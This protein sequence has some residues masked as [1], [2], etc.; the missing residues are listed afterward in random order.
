MNNKIINGFCLN[1]QELSKI[2]N[3]DQIKDKISTFFIGIKYG[4]LVTNGFVLYNGK[5]KFLKNGYISEAEDKDFY[6]KYVKEHSEAKKPVDLLHPW[7]AEKEAGIS[8]IEAGI[9]LFYENNKFY[10]GILYSNRDCID[11]THLK[12]LA[13]KFNLDIKNACII[14]IDISKFK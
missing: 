12:L 13:D 11:D 6:R 9:S 5:I 2:F 8:K 4:E 10:L 7:V 1:E 14:D 3:G